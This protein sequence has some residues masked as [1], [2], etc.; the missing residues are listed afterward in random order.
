MNIKKKGWIVTDRENN[1]NIPKV[2]LDVIILNTILMCLGPIL[3]E[4]LALLRIHWAVK[5][6][7]SLTF[8]G[9]GALNEETML[10]IS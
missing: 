5:L 9:K 6:N 8:K 1:K 4:S 7:E 3:I 10:L 2:S